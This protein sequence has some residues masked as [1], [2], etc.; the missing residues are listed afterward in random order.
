MD[1]ANYRFVSAREELV[2]SGERRFRT[3]ADLT[4]SLT[5]AGFAVEHVFGGWQRRPVDVGCS[6][7]ISVAVP[8]PTCADLPSGASRTRADMTRTTGFAVASA[9]T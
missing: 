9:L 4:Q 3:Q 6:E 7:L 1:A 8:E 5:D 2:S